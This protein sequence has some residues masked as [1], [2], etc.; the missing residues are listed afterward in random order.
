MFEVVERPEGQRYWVVRAQGGD[1]IDHF[2]E[3]GVVAVGHLNILGL[4]DTGNSA[5]F[6]DMGELLARL[7]EA[8]LRKNKEQGKIGA[9][10]K[11]RQIRTFIGEMAV[12]DLVVS[13]DS[14]YLMVGRVI[15]HPR[16]DRNPIRFVYDDKN[17]N[18]SEMNFHL[19]RRVKWGPR[20]KRS[21]LP[22]AMKRSVSARQTVFNID[23]Y[24]TAIYHMLYP[25][26]SY[27]NRIYLS[28]RINQD[29]SISNYSIS[30]LFA[31]LTDLEVLCRSVEFTEKPEEINFAKLFSIIFLNDDFVL[32]TT[33][34]FMSPGSVW[35]YLGFSEKAGRGILVGALLFG[36]I[37]GAKVGPIE[38]DGILHKELREKLLE[39]FNQRLLHHNAE[40]VKEKLE[41]S[42]P[43]FNTKPLEDSADDEPEDRR[44]LAILQQV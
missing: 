10:R 13:I 4:A 27:E 23:S 9:E 19:R 38:V 14:G 37:F 32:T 12:G 40:A 36:A 16:I 31:I 18:Y 8:E 1:Y 7:R 22:T 30:Q 43:R 42:V 15:G 33:A 17:N 2:R 3:G 20:I 41:L 34:E 6:P 39:E 24:W 35:S 11:F 28:T 29:G 21:H 26:F 5:Y 25:V 44:R